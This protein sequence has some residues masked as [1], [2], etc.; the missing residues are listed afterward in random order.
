MSAWVLLVEDNP[1][2]QEL[3]HAAWRRARTSTR[4]ELADD[5]AEAFDRLAALVADGGELPVL[6]LTDLRMPRM[7]GVELVRRL[8]G[9]PG[10]TSLPVVVLSSSQEPEE[11]DRC[12]RSGANAFVVKPIGGR[13][14]PRAV[15]AIATFWSEL[16]LRPPEVA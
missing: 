14:D 15:D 7:D 16:N 2:D 4:L 10:T 8:R 5:G 1:A 9:H 6:V 13:V 11:V 3:L 12:Y